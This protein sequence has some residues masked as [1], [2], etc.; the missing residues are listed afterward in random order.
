MKEWL[1]LPQ[2]Y[3]VIEHVFKQ[4]ASASPEQQAR[5]DDRLSAIDMGDSSR[6]LRTAGNNAQINISG[7][8]T[9]E[10]DFFAMVFGGGN[11]AYSEIL[12]AFAQ[13]EADD[14]VSEITLAIDSPGGEVAGLFEVTDAIAATKKPVTVVVGSM[15][16][17]AAYA[18]ASQGDKVL[19][20]NRASR[21]GSVGIVQSFFVND[22]IVDIT[23]TN[24]PD[25][26]PNPTTPEGKATIQ[27]QLDDI[28]DIFVDAI[29]IGRKTTP[30][31]VNSDFGRGAML[32]AN[33]A[34]GA[35]MIDDLL[36]TKQINTDNKATANAVQAKKEE[37]RKMDLETL[38][39]QHADVYN[40]VVA[41]GRDQERARVQGH[42]CLGDAA[43]AMDIALKAIEEGTESNDPLTVAKYNA[44]IMSKKDVDNRDADNEEAKKALENV[45]NSN[46]TVESEADKKALDIADFVAQGLKGGK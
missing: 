15:A 20:S 32:V 1:L 2:T 16:A 6:I 3:S 23:S 12:A 45:D 44:A 22:D 26:R 43:N 9:K 40:A 24:A 38:K 46:A 28:H 21:V 13:A 39:A 7:V 30:D 42:L 8:L 25:K 19:A 5:V 10:P 18:I 41:V 4:G 31:K 27:A 14:S 17:S 29:A 33:D 34:L 35:G 36:S 11:T 37:G